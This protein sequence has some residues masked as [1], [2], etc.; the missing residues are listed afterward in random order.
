MLNFELYNPN[1]RGK[2]TGDC[3]KRAIQVATEMDYHEL[4]VFMNRNKVV[5]S[6]PYN[7]GK[8]YEH[9]INLLG[10]KTI[11]MS[12]P[13]GKLRWHVN[14]IDKVM[15]K[16]SNVKYVLRVSKHMIGI[17]HGTI[18]D[19]FDDRRRNKGIYKMWVFNATPEQVYR[20]QR[21]CSLGDE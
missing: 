21:E 9:V 1:C 11:K 15:S 8:N 12:V 5:K 19:T 4:E 14:T 13:S 18:Y 10:G 3:C 16:Y 17:K 7:Y 6:Q 20:I 2:I